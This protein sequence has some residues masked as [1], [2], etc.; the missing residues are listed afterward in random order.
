MKFLGV[1]PEGTTHLILGQTSAL[2]LEIF[3][4]NAGEPAY[5]ALL[6]VRLPPSVKYVGGGNDLGLVVNSPALSTVSFDLGNPLGAGRNATLR[7]KLNVDN[8]PMATAHLYFRAEMT[9]TSHEENRTSLDNK[10]SISLP[11]MYEVELVMER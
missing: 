10:A 2:G 6:T 7:V 1:N 4:S 3:V 8:V 11:A 9:S 5:E